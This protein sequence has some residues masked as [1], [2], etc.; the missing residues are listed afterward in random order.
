MNEY[1][2]ERAHHQAKENASNMYDDHYVRNHNADEYNPNQ[3][4]APQQF[5][6]GGDDY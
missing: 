3:Y 1:E 2:R 5:R 6:R 4:D